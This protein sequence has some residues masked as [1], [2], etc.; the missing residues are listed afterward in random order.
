M[1]GDLINA[2]I[3]T[4]SLPIQVVKDVGKVVGNESPHHTKDTLEDIWEDIF[5]GDG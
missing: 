1:L 2:A 4:V 3:R 5:E